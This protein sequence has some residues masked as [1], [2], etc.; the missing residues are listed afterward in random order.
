MNI[1]LVYRI[2]QPDERPDKYDRSVFYGWSKNKSIIKVFT[3]QRSKGKYHLIKIDEDDISNLYP[4]S[5]KS[6]V[7]DDHMIDF[8]ILKSVSTG[9]SYH[10]ITTSNELCNAEILIQRMM[11]DASS[12][13]ED[14]FKLNDINL[15][16]NI[17]DEYL[18]ALYYIGF[19][20]DDLDILYPSADYHDDIN[21]IQTIEEDIEDAYTYPYDESRFEVS[22]RKPMGM[23]NFTDISN[24]ILYSLEAFVKVLKD[25]L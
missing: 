21:N 16:Y 14:G 17:K 12:L 20:P 13:S 9:E 6:P 19:R 8:V 10:F 3:Q 11:H 25:D 2:Y 1:Y 22:K 15:F 4:D 7:D 18:K 24:K 5:D 23:M